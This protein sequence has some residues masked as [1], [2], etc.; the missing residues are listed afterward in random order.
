MERD[1]VYSARLRVRKINIRPWCYLLKSAEYRSAE[2]GWIYELDDAW[3]RAR[4]TGCCE[5]TGL[6]FEKG[7][8]GRGPQ[9]FSPTVDRINASLGYTKS[10]TR[11][12]LMGCNALKGS[13]TDTDMLKIARAICNNF[14]S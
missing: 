9:P 10:N 4:W 1:A 14:P 5:I 12:I 13:G 7:G 6:P 11:F 2:K 3:A 8:N